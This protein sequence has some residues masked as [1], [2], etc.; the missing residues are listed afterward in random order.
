MSHLNRSGKKAEKLTSSIAST[1]PQRCSSINLNMSTSRAMT[2]LSSGEN[3][4][5]LEDDNLRPRERNISG[6]L[7]KNVYLVFKKRM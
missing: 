4:E 2:T 7:K 3:K 5:L 6:I 1:Q